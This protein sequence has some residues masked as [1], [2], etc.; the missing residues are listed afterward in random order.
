MKLNFAVMVLFLASLC[1]RQSLFAASAADSS[2]LSP[3]D[4]Y[5]PINGVRL[6][7][8]VAGQ[9]PLVLVTSPGWGIGSIYLQN[10][11]APLEQHFT[12]LFI[13]TRGSGKSTRPADD[14]Q[15]GTDVMAD[16][17]EAMRRYL[18]LSS[19]ALMGHSGGGTI[20]LEY[21][22]RHPNTA[23]KIVLLDPGILGDP[24]YEA[25]QH[26]LDLWRYDPRY[27]Q[28]VLNEEESEKK[29]SEPSSDEE[30]ERYLA[31]TLPLYFSDPD[32]YVLPFIQ[33]YADTHL[34]S[35]AERM[36]NAADGR[37][38]RK[39][40][41][42]YD[43]VVARTFILNGTVDWVCLPEGALR[44]HAGIRGSQLSLYANAGHVLWIEQPQRFFAELTRFLEQ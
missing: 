34:S 2:K 26:A 11:L 29:N 33:T 35:Y 41:Q 37:V 7:Y 25:T 31:G 9:G 1:C 10:G 40:A 42:D 22:E 20:A 4:H 44:A 18:G 17:V 23:D 14:T 21:A 38:A 30:F 5:A 15:M 16:D 36:H 8:Y 24:A 39:Q 12:M 27:Q 6:H 3:G 28:A 19:I 13:D 43:K 32:R